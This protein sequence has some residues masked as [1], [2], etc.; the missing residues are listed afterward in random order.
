M[1]ILRNFWIDI[2]KHQVNDYDLLNC[3]GKYKVMNNSQRE[4]E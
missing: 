1:L 4:V 2:K 3:Q